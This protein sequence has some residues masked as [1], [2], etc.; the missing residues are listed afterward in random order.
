[1]PSLSPENV[2]C[3]AI[4]SQSLQI[5]W[6]NPP[7]EGRN[8]VIQG[9]KL[10]YSPSEE[11]AFP[12]S[13][14]LSQIPTSSS[15]SP[16]AFLS[17]A[18]SASASSSSS[19]T[20]FS[21]GS[22][23]AHVQQQQ[24]K[25]G[26]GHQH[27][28]GG[29]NAGGGGGGSLSTSSSLESSSGGSAADFNVETKLTTE[30]ELNVHGLER[31]TNYTVSVLAFTAA[32]DGK[33]SEPLICHTDEDGKCSAFQK[34]DTCLHARMCVLLGDSSI[35]SITQNFTLF[36]MSCNRTDFYLFIRISL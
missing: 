34:M 7:M 2:G 23:S 26:S 31:W 9:Y 25:S 6:D 17:A 28:D 4:S 29:S 30:R 3:K 15:S 8:G 35:Q 22:S 1:M 13:L 16:S 33:L 36:F 11:T 12:S 21:S 10:I 32:G 19:S 20:S 5:T 18:A 14:L 27:S 24:Q